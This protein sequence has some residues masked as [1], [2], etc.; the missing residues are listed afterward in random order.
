M[1]SNKK[2]YISLIFFFLL[3]IFS[4]FYFFENKKS[5][6]DISVQEQNKKEQIEFDVAL[7]LRSKIVKNR[8]D[9]SSAVLRDSYIEMKD[10]YFSKELSK[11]TRARAGLNIAALLTNVY[12]KDIILNDILSDKRFSGF[13]KD[14][15]NK[16]ISLIA[17]YIYEEVSDMN[18]NILASWG[19]SN[20]FYDYVLLDKNISLQDKENYLK[21]AE[22]MYQ[23]GEEEFK[24]IKDYPGVSNEDINYLS[25]L[26]SIRGRILVKSDL[27]NKE[28]TWKTAEGFISI[29]K[30]LEILKKQ[31]SDK[32]SVE[33]DTI[34]RLTYGYLLYSSGIEKEEIIKIIDPIFD[35]EHLRYRDFII[36][37]FK[38]EKTPEHD[39]HFFKKAIKRVGI[40]D[41]RVR[42]LMLE[43]GFEEDFF[44]Y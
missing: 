4:T 7:E 37:I 36:N 34:T 38:L 30:S 25:T 28:K 32:N 10:S 20:L 6:P 39:F 5:A 44:K 35:E 40:I 31:Y 42:G 15:T 23:R 17:A 24:K 12:D 13:A 2:N 1:K 9:S 26:L 29:D 22:T 33:T 8:F 18:K 3:A 21:K 19:A 14:K 43:S 41:I 27:A 16:S 11:R